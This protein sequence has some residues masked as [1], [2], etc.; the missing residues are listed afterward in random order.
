MM[1]KGWDKP[2]LKDYTELP[3][4]IEEESTSGQPVLDRR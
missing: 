1:P 4:P 3:L 2:Q